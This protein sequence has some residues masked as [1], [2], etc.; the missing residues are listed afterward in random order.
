MLLGRLFPTVAQ[1]PPLETGDLL[2]ATNTAKI[3]RIP[4]SDQTGV[5]M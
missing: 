1:T 3:W 4:T 2:I 5:G